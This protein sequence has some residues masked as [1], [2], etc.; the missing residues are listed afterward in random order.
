MVALTMLLDKVTMPDEKEPCKP[1]VLSYKPGSAMLQA[2]EHLLLA[3]ALPW[4]GHRP[5]PCQDA[6]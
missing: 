3:P 1:G 4:R 6:G 5:A 2:W